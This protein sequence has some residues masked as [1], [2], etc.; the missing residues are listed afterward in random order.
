MKNSSALPYATAQPI[1]ASEALRKKLAKLGLRSSADLVV[2]LPLRYEDETR[3]TLMAK[4]P[5]GV[6]VQVEATVL[7]SEIQ[8][9]PRRQ[10]VVWV[11][12]ESGQLCLRFFNFYPNQRAMLEPGARLRIFGEIREG[13][14]G[15][16]MVH[17][18]FAKASA[19]T[20]LPKTLTPVYPTTA[21]VAQS[22]LR[23][24]IA[25]AIETADLQETLPPELDAA[26]SLPSF[27]EAVRFLHF[28]PAGAVQEALEARTHPAWQRVKF[29]EVLAQQLSLRRAYLARRQRGAPALSCKGELAHRFLAA[30]PF[31]LTGAQTRA[32]NELVADL[33]QPY[34]MQRLLQGDVGSG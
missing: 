25:Q 6:P 15:A 16:E 27:A 33:A 23:K 28:P 12:D 19:E 10:L 32:S 13:F 31:A 1:R 8:F 20:P 30:L 11:E 3:I 29:E 18:R 4:A 22:A 14:F 7:S 34:P 24:L 26:L 17:P 2:H 5:S 21:G 9:R